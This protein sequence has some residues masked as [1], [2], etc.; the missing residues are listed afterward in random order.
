MAS[1]PSIMPS[2]SRLGDATEPANPRGQSLKLNAFAREL[3]PTRQCFVLRKYFERQFVGARDIV[4]IAAQR[5]PAKRATAF[6]KQRT[7]VFGNE[8]WN[9]E[10]VLDARLLR[11]SAN[12]VS[13]IECDCAFLL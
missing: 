5:D 9:V 10:R 13:V 7:N 2:V 4:W 12:V 11:L 1:L 8:P 6:A 3:H